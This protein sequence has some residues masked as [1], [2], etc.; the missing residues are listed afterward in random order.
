MNE[1][2]VETLAAVDLGSNSFH[3]I[4]AKDLNGQ[5][6]LL[7]RLRE[8][9]ALAEGLTDGGEMRLEI[10]ERAMEC[11]KRFGQRLRF[12]PGSAVR[13]VGTSTLRQLRD[14]GAFLRRAEGA[15]GHPIDIISGHEEARLVYLGVAHTAPF[16]PGHRLVV[17]I[18]GGS[19]ELIVG[20][21]FEVE[22]SSSLHMGCV[23]H[24]QRFFPD[25]KLGESAFEKAEL[26]A[27]LEVR[28]VKQRF[29]SFAAERVLGS[30]GTIRAIASI[31]RERDGGDGTITAEALKWL[32][33]RM[34]DAKS[35]KKLDLPGMGADRAPVLPGGVAILSSL[36][37][38]LKIDKM[39]AT[40]GALREGLL[41]DLIGR[42]HH[43]DIRDRSIRTLTQRYQ[44]D[45]D[46]TARVERAA[47]LFFE[48]A[49]DAWKLDGYGRKLLSWA[50]R[51]HEIGLSISYEDYHLHGAYLVRHS[52]MPGFS[53]D[54]KTHL[55]TL[56]LAH[57]S[58]PP[59]DLFDAIEPRLRE[60]MRGL[61]GLFRLAVRLNRSR[62]S[63]AF[64]RLQLS[65]EKDA[66]RLGIPR[67]WL[68]QHL[69][70][71]ADLIQEQDRFE[72]LGLRLNIG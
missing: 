30:S 16:S 67:G 43:A 59:K 40:H 61:C 15:L 46:Q 44:V 36:F 71:R 32:K 50:A 31:L 56:I 1:K 21:G 22:Q 20:E 51:L 10:A 39:E 13:A 18:G 33:E 9:V 66:L 60:P 38:A 7:D 28:A 11:L 34:I 4:V 24:T 58:K 45:L 29:Q 52:D 48:Q 68:D 27:Q 54:D 26:A 63:R 55:A 65:V 23:Q 62:A 8:R 42:M 69:L 41:Y 14:G 6:H 3:M 57:R 72:L 49:R 37:R 53:I 12:M 35:V 17:D 5:L 2:A 25:G 47:L 64:P 19:T 70:T